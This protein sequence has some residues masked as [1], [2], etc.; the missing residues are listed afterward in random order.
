MWCPNCHTDV[1]AEV[2]EKDSA[3]VC[4]SCGGEVS[5]IRAPSLHPKTREAR[6]L[7]E[8][9]SAEELLEPYGPAMTSME[10]ERSVV[11]RPSSVVTDTEP[12]TTD[13]RQ[14]TTG[15]GSL[16]ADN[17]H[18]DDAPRTTASPDRSS[19][20]PRR[21]VTRRRPRRGSHRFESSHAAVP[22][23]HF[24]I[25]SA[26]DADGKR[27]GRSES[28]WGQ[29]LAYVGVG[30]L[31]VGTVL[32]LWGYFGGPANYTP[33]GWLMA[34]AGQ[35]LLFLGVVTLISGGMEQTTHEV[36][37]RIEHLSDHIIR[38]ERHTMQHSQR[39]PHVSTEERADAAETATRRP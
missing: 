29:L 26:L 28:L 27:P 11:R 36:A 17:G 33:T 21:H 3:L 35:M 32:V 9:W 4:T 15:D 31:T 34:T 22:P 8:R 7:L 16:T 39:G 2:S 38:I 20:R 24:T 14:R 18:R 1:A 19:Q 30:L 25:A 37:Q 23:P 6:D 13:D 10:S 12:L 5:S